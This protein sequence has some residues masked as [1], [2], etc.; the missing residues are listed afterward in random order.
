LLRSEQAVAA[1]HIST[2]PLKGVLSWENEAD[3]PEVL[4]VPL[5]SEYILE[6][7]TAQSDTSDGQ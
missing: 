5:E 4:R 6:R 2:L 1:V 3:L 7:L